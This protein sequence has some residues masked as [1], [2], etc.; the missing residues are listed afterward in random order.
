MKK[1]SSRFKTPIKSNKLFLHSWS[2]LEEYLRAAPHLILS[3]SCTEKDKKRLQ[4][5]LSAYG[6]VMP[7]Q[8]SSQGFSAEIRVLKNTEIEL[9]SD[10][11]RETAPDKILILDHLSDTRN[12]GAIVRSA[13]YFGV[14]H[15]VIARNRQASVTQGTIDACQGAF[16]ECKLYEVTNLVRTLKKLKSLDFWLVGGDLDGQPLDNWQSFDKTCLVVGS[17]DKGMGE[18]VKKLLD[19]RVKIP[20]SSQ[21]DS[22]NVS[23]ATGILLH[24]LVNH[25]SN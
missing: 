18:S 22:L 15:I 5:L 6:H 23:V 13:A 7:I 25:R 24:E 14:R 10:L 17:E 21:I 20:A 1:N 12:F 3:L 11:V 9:E 16:A 19:L 2:A 4:D 8:A